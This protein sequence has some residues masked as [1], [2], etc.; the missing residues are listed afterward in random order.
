MLLR[1]LLLAGVL[2]CVPATA[3]HAQQTTA[4]GVPIDAD[5]IARLDFTVMPDGEGLPAGS[6]TAS[7]GAD[8]YRQH[9]LAC[10]GES[11][12]GGSND[13][14]AGGQGSLA[15][16]HP[17]KTIGSY[18]PY[19]PTLFDYIRRAMPYPTPGSLSN[20]ELYAVT[21]YLLY[22][23]EIIDQDTIVDKAS[24][25]TIEMPNRNGF[26]PEYEPGD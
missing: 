10:H 12:I 19:A 4:L 22:L 2:L 6:G 14:L 20:D 13:Q 26:D 7:A 18:W 9:C 15:T 17:Q 24:L 21:A 5:D 23:N 16:E 11:G 8:V 3:G 25:P 1:D